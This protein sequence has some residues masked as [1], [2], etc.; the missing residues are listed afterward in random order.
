MN[1]RQG[2]PIPDEKK[3]VVIA[4]L[5]AGQGVN[6]I[7]EAYKIPKSSVS[8]LKKII[9][10]EKLEQVGIQKAETI[11]VLISNN[12]EASFDAIHN[13]LKQTQDVDWLKK[14]PASELATFLGV[15]SDKVFRVLEAIENAQSPAGEPKL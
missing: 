4:A 5:L 7:A 3:A 8:R 2:K 9:P 14:Q 11:A 6:E 12:L 13:I 15:T 1:G 10:A